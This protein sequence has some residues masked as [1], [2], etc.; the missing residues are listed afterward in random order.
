VLLI[1]RTFAPWTPRMRLYWTG[2]HAEAI[3]R[4]RGYRDS[5]VWRVEDYAAQ[6]RLEM[7]K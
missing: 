5:H 7:A 2:T 3:S 6:G 1:D 4:A